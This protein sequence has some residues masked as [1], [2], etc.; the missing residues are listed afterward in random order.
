[1]LPRVLKNF[2]VFVEGVGYAGR[3]AEIELPAFKVKGE[4]IRNGGMEAPKS[5]DMGIELLT[6]KLTFDEYLPELMTRV[7]LGDTEGTR[8]QFRGAIQRNNEDAI[9]VVVDM[10]GSFDEEE[11]GSWKSG[12]KAQN[13]ITMNLGYYKLM[14]DGNRIR[15]IDVDNLIRY[16]GDTDVMESIRAAIGV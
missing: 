16:V 9:P 10:H 12:D 8:V 6:A 1:M 3:V 7:G 11:M 2:N 4:E 13:Q 5:I 14:I 15:E